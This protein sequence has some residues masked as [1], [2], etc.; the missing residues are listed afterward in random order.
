M[1]KTTIYLGLEDKDTKQVHFTLDYVQA[2]LADMFSE[3]GATIQRANGIYKYNDDTIASE[4][5]FIIT[6]FDRVLDNEFYKR[7]IKELKN[8]FNQ[9]LILVERSEVVANFV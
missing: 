4:P 8:E 3:H 5:T 1:I 6:L 2:Y 7:V 9:E